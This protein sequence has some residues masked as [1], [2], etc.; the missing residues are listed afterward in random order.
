MGLHC[1]AINDAKQLFANRLKESMQALKLEPIP[2]VLEREFNQKNTGDDVTLHGVHKWLRG[3]SIPV[4]RNLAILELWLKADFL[5]FRPSA[6]NQTQPRQTRQNW[7]STLLITERDAV[8]A[9]LA[10]PAPQRKI[11]RAVILAFAK[12]AD[13]WR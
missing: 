7:Q 2:S 10:L 13:E 4:W 5:S 3:E 6:D 9:Y 12:T 8:D 11:V 1:P